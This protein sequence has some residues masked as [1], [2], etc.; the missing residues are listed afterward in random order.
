MRDT[1]PRRYRPQPAAPEQVADPT[2]P[3]RVVLHTLHRRATLRAVYTGAAFSGFVDVSDNLEAD[4]YLLRAARHHGEATAR[5]CPICRRHDLVHLSY[6][7][8]DEF[9]PDTNG[10]L[11]S[12]ADLPEIA[13][14]YGHIVVYVVEVCTRCSWNHIVMTYVLG[15]GNPRP[16][17]RAARA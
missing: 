16:P 1:G 2:A 11:R 7:F 4:P 3:R 12:S 14:E 13:V 10:R 8:S 9:P 15:D 6:T 17:G 5:R